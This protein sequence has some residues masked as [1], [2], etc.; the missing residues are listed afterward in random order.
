MSDIKSWFSVAGSNSAASP[1]GAP[2]L[3]ARSGVNDTIREA[4]ASV[5]RFYDDP[6]L[7]RPFEDY[8]FARSSGTQFTLTNATIES[9]AASLMEAGQRIKMIG[10]GADAGKIWE[11][12]VSDTPA[13]PTYSAPVTT[14]HVAWVLADSEDIVGPTVVPAYLEV[15]TKELGQAAW[16]DVGTAA[17]KIP[18]YDS[19]DPHVIKTEAAL[20][21]GFLGT[22][23]REDIAMAG[24]RGRLNTNGGFDFWQRGNSFTSTTAYTNDDDEV[25]ADNWTMIA[26]GNDMIDVS[27]DTSVFP[28]TAPVKSSLKVEAGGAATSNQKHG[29]IT[30]IESLDGLDVSLAGGTKTVSL[31]FWAKVG[32]VVG[33]SAIRAYVLNIKNT[34]PTTSPVATW[35][36]G[37]TG[38]VVFTATDWEL[39]SGGDVDPFLAVTLAGSWTEYKIEGI[40]LD[41]S[42]AG[43]GGIAIAFIVDD[44]AFSAGASWH[45]AGVQLVRGSKALPFIRI[46]MATEFTQCQ[47]YFESTFDEELQRPAHAG[48]NAHALMAHA[49]DQGD[50]GADW[51]F[52]APKFKL[53]TLATYNPRVAAPSTGNWDDGTADRAVSSSEITR[54]GVHILCTTGTVDIVH[55]IGAVAHAN[56]W[57][58]D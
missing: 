7:R 57:G 3:M 35:A 18:T 41:Q 9:N 39:P 40:E 16:Y 1:N 12:F 53:P 28:S 50:F 23:T 4:M 44:A 14:F 8:T 48:G 33:V 55:R 15:G 47:R 38:N 52:S 37:S 22:E 17:G 49:N 10:V 21:V 6:G 45:I 30:F 29:I 31:S 11:G 32:A 26:D 58:S 19:L 25:C 56:V 34:I 36:N 46:P 24:A 2:E 27:K 5:K 20:D 43:G 13:V 51:R 54:K 42:G